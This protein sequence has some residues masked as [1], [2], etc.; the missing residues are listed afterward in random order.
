MCFGSEQTESHPSRSIFSRSNM[1]RRGFL[2][3]KCVTTLVSENFVLGPGPSDLINPKLSSWQ[4]MRTGLLL[5]TYNL[6]STNFT[7]LSPPP[8]PRHYHH[9]PAHPQ[10]SWTLPLVLT[11]PTTLRSSVKSKLSADHFDDGY[12]MLSA[13]KKVIVPALNKPSLHLHKRSSP[14]D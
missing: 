8:P 12:L 1:L 5:P 4:T 14:Y 6:Y 2:T 3:N 9:A 13:I 11:P 7:T 10:I